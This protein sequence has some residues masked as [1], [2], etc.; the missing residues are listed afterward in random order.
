MDDRIIP[1]GK[2]KGKP[3]EVLASDKEYLEWLIAQ[4]WF[5]DKHI[6]LYN[7][8]I[9]NFREPVDTPE[10]N[11]IQIKF[12]N[13]EYRLKLAFL[14]NPNLFH[15]NSKRINEDMH[16]ILNITENDQNKYFLNALA[17]PIKES[18]YGLCSKE[19]LNFS[20]PVFEIVDVKYGI[21]Y[22]LK[23]NYTTRYYSTEFYGEILTRYFIEIKPTISDD[24]PAIL[25]QMKASMP[26]D[27]NYYA[28][29][30]FYILLVGN[31]TGIGATRKEFIDFFET[32]GYKVIFIDE[33][34]NIKLP[35]FDRELILDK[36]LEDLI[37][38]AA[39]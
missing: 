16:S 22:G 13:K 8:I 30:I 37:K 20:V 25:R 17:N 7:V 5:K 23:F 9:N 31:Y 28:K 2:H 26:I 19:L 15:Y 27:R 21:W 12:L 33:I 38:E 32:Q 10:H 4:S 14:V 24:Y 1:F 36:E 3:V 6:N 11:K 29:N 39:K 34:E 35:E 18:K